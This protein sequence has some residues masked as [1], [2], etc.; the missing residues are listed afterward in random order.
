MTTFIGALALLMT[1]YPASADAYTT[2]GQRVQKINE[3]TAI[4]FIN[5]AFG[6][7]NY[8][9]YLPILAKR[10]QEHGTETKTIGFEVLAESEERT[11]IGTVQALALSKASIENGMY[12]VPKGHKLPFTFAAILTTDEGAIE[13][14]YAVRIT[15]LPFFMGAES[16]RLNPS[17]LAYY[18]TP[19]VELNE[20]NTQPESVRFNISV[21]DI[22]YRVLD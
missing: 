17:E 16:E 9:L 8:D 10:D 6:H 4:F 18:I 2:T 5:Y 20:S 12:K 22:E 14:D 19:E 11:E 1:L 7:E 21:K 3:T 15:D 13:T